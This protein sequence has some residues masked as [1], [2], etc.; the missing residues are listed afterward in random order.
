MERHQTRLGPEPCDRQ[1]HHRRGGRRAVQHS[2]RHVPAPRIAG[3]EHGEHH[4][5]GRGQVGRDQI[6]EGRGA[7]LGALVIRG[8]K[9]ARGECHDLPGDQQQHQVR[10]SHDQGHR[11]Q[12]QV[13]RDQARAGRVAAVPGQVACPEHGG[14]RA[15]NRDR[16]KEDRRQRVE[17]QRQRRPG[18]RPAG[19][20]A[21]GR[22]THQ[23]RNRGERRRDASGDRAS[24]AEPRPARATRRQR[25]PEGACD[26]EPERGEQRRHAGDDP[27]GRASTSRTRASSSPAP[28]RAS[29]SA[30]RRSSWSA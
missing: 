22:R 11:R 4:Q 16:K 14:G 3:Q 8:Q 9:R 27:I 26:P 10:G 5:R 2:R 18:H 25:R 23:H 17:P 12:Q 7:H 13:E 28:A 6:A 1:R 21:G 15:H 20:D 19:F 29:S 30:R 24:G